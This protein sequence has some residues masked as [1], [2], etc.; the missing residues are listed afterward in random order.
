MKQTR[1]GK[2]QRIHIFIPL[3]LF[4][5]HSLAT[6]GLATAA[7]TSLVA[8]ANDGGD[9]VTRDELRASQN[10]SSVLNRVWDGSNIQVFGAKNEIVSFNLVLEAPNAA[11]DAVSIAFDRLEGPEGATITSREVA[12]DDVFD[13]TGRNI[14]LFYVRYLQ[15]QGLS[16]LSYENYDE[17]HIPESFRR[18]WTGDGEGTGWWTDRPDHDKFYPD[19][20]VPLE[21]VFTVQRWRRSKSECLGGHLHSQDGFGRRIPG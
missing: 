21:L 7:G 4:A 13:W 5:L 3:L 14:E 6:A 9:K 1:T 15:I 18:P 11:V 8:W 12:G 20:A 10:P 17:R 2:T 19:I 16:L